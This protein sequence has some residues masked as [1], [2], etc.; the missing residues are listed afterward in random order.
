MKNYEVKEILITHDKFKQDDC[1]SQL[2]W[3]SRGYWAGKRLR[4]TIAQNIREAAINWPQYL[5]DVESEIVNAFFAPSEHSCQDF[6]GTNFIE[7]YNT[8]RTFLLLVAEE[9][10]S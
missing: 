4:S 10:E 6:D 2:Y 7:T 8:F 9:L 5:G 3:F 1:G